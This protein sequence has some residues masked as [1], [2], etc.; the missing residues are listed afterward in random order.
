[1]KKAIDGR[2]ILTQHG[3][4]Y[5]VCPKCHNDNAMIDRPLPHDPSYIWTCRDCGFEVNEDEIHHI[6]YPGYPDSYFIR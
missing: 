6:E 1:M 2:I 3:S 5:P 4:N